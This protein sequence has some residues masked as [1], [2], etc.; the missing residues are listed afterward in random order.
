[1]RKFI[2]FN[3]GQWLWAFVCL[4]VFGVSVVP[5]ARL[6]MEM[7]NFG[8][9]GKGLAL[10][11]ILQSPTTWVVAGHSLVTSTMGSLLAVILGGGFAYLVG[12]C[13]IRRKGVLV[14]CFMLPMMIPPQISA[15]SWLQ[16]FGPSSPLLLFLGMAPPLGSPQPLYSVE[17]IVLLLGIQQAPLVFLALRGTLG[18][19]PKEMVEAA[20]CS[21]AGHF[22]V[23]KDHI[24][25]LSSPGLIAGAGIA[26]VSSLGNFGIPAMLGIPFSYYSL[27]TLIYQK[28]T[29]F[30]EDIIGSV[31]VLALIIGIIALLAVGLQNYFLRRR[32]YRLLGFNGSALDFDLGA[33]R[34]PV[35]IL[36]W[37]FLFV[38]LAF[39]LISLVA[40]S[41]VPAYGVALNP[42]TLSLASY[43]EVFFHQDATQRAFINS[44]SLSFSAALLLLLVTLPLGYF[45]K[46]NKQKIMEYLSLA[47][48]IPYALPGMV[49]GISCILLFVKPLPFLGISIYG[50]IAIL[51]YAYV[52]RFMA[53]S[54]K[55]IAA[56]ILQL[57]PG[58]EEAAASCGA[59]LFQRL[60]HIFLPLVAPA[61]V[62]A[63]ILVFLSAFN[64]LTLSALLWSAGN[65]TLGVLIFNL[66]DSGDSVLASAVAVISVLV[67]LSLM[68][69]LD[70]KADSLP[71]G[72]VPWRV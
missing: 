26:F 33:W 51:F 10:F 24:L 50:S 30:G 20:R 8:E 58:L 28:L 66:D 59:N 68:Y 46:S 45:L 67:V 40:S 39:P 14:F 42:E 41:L 52:A 54:L 32:D 34:L 43:T 62:A 15:L 53:V 13:N 4:A 7:F 29:D 23:W 65:E 63:A 47:V 19:L 38:I 17:G 1:M 71:K 16:L 35:E 21:G 3:Q 60:R 31:A 2:A 12:L 57:D 6:I 72:V 27:P 37:G 64:E 61:A 11:D 5:V 9:P 25:P 36:V 44:L 18:A 55:P 56:S 70:R 22:S 48:E 69:C 49:L